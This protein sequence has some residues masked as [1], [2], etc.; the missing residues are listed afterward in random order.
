MSLIT[1]LQIFWV[2]KVGIAGFQSAGSDVFAV[3]NGRLIKWVVIVEPIGAKDFQL[4]KDF[5]KI[6][7]QV[8]HL[9]V[10]FFPLTMHKIS[11]GW[12]FFR[13]DWLFWAMAYSSLSSP[14]ISSSL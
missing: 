13:A 2:L 8:H 11:R 9:F 10:A 3:D 1:N 6:P 4:G 7:L 14:M 5:M 12:R